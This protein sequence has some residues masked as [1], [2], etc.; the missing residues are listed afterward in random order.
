VRSAKRQ[1]KELR[2][3]IGRLVRHGCLG[4]ASPTADLQAQALVERM[5]V[6]VRGGFCG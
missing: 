3:R 2:G 5:R 6:L 1:V 4:S